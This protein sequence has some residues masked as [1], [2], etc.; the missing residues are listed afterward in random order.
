MRT[1]IDNRLKQLEK[2][3]GQGNE[4]I[5]LKFHDGTEWTLTVD[6]LDQA[7]KKAQGTFLVPVELPPGQ[8]SRHH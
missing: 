4:L 5:T 1:G 8:T 3:L 2:K 6:E 7:I